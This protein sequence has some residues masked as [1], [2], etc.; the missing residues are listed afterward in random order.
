[1][2]E[3]ILAT[4]QVLRKELT[5]DGGGHRCV[6]DLPPMTFPA[7]KFICIQGPSG[8]GKTTLLSLLGLVDSDYVG[9]LSMCLDALNCLPAQ[10]HGF[11]S[12]RDIAGPSTRRKIGF[13]F[14]DVRLRPSL[15]AAQNVSDPLRYLGL[16]S[17]ES[18]A[19]QARECLSRLGIGP[20]DQCRRVS[21]FSGGMQQRTAIARAL[22]TR[23]E[24]ICAD[25]PT[26]NLDDDLAESIYRDLKQISIEHGISVIVVTHDRRWAQKFAD[27]T[28][29]IEAMHPTFDRME[30][31]RMST[32]PYTARLIYPERAPELASG[33]V[34]DSQ[35]A[36]SL[37]PAPLERPG[38]FTRIADVVKESADEYRNLIRWLLWAVSPGALLSRFV[39]RKRALRRGIP[40]HLYL[41]QLIALVTCSLLC[42][43][44]FVFYEVK[45]ALLTYQDDKLNELQILRRVRIESPAKQDGTLLSLDS[46]DLAT[47]VKSQGVELEEIIPR[48]VL[49]GSALTPPDIRYLETQRQYPHSILRLSDAAEM[50]T[51]D[52]MLEDSSSQADERLNLT[53]IGLRP[54]DPIAQDLGIDQDSSLASGIQQGLPGIYITP[55]QFDWM[56]LGNFPQRPD[57]SQAVPIVFIGERDIFPVD[58]NPSETGA[59][60]SPS[61]GLL[62]LRFN[63]EGYLE[64]K[65]T[66]AFSLETNDPLA[67]G[68]IHTS[69]FQKIIQWKADPIDAQHQIPNAWRCEPDSHQQIAMKYLDAALLREPMPSG[70][71][72]FAREPRDVMTLHSIV[73]R[74]GTSREL[75]FGDVYSER[76]LVY[77]LVEIMNMIGFIGWVMMV[78]P[79]SIGMVILWLTIQGLFERKRD[80]LLLCVVMG[81]SSRRLQLQSFV[82]TFFLVIP[83]LLIGYCL[84][85]QLP[86]AITATQLLSSLDPHLLSRLDASAIDLYGLACIGGIALIGT[87]IVSLSAV[88][89][90]IQTNPADAFR[91]NL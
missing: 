58:E 90:I 49:F 7:G 42:S 30:T 15:D 82:S 50:S 12:P 78:L 28:L 45:E 4:W 47:F 63:V 32:W 1:M 62:C 84:A 26:A 35:H 39:R 77:E 85:V 53:L 80:Q 88:Q 74:Y 72:L 29:E 70:Y 16:G 83:S 61:H 33:R 57:I 56:T 3:A 41:P 89:D 23:P 9:D 10:R 86:L 40:T 44:A 64:P 21:S 73:E 13:I 60:S 36:S 55:S 79:I 2:T 6:L 76:K 69:T 81:T 5:L 43:A 65:E 18:R 14:Q 68:A 91:G 11:F 46:K 48:Y 31:A 34:V 66:S 24:L 67:Q 51:L 20:S 25:E 37:L 87:A 19:H 54:G 17:A 8:C 22:A 27:V 59:S 71:D 75:V 52:T 38:V